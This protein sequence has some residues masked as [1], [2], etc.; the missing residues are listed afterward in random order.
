M[1]SWCKSGLEQSRHLDQPAI[2]GIDTESKALEGE[3]SEQRLRAGVAADH[4]RGLDA[5][6]EPHAH[7]SHRVAHLAPVSQHKHALLI[8]PHTKSFEDVTWD[9]RV[10]C[11]GV[12][13]RLDR[14]ELL[15]TNASQ[16]DR[17]PERPHSRI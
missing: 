15:S 11:A 8:G 5:V 1:C 16:L 12:H 9:P 10:R 4:E 17:N 14:F 7:P 3:R 13:Q 6:I 2:H